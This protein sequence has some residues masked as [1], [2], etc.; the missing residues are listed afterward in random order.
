MPGLELPQGEITP[1]VRPAPHRPTL[2]ARLFLAVNHLPHTHRSDRYISDLSD[3]G[4][5]AGWIGACV[6]IAA[7]GGRR[8]RRAAL[9]AL[10]AAGV[11]TAVVEGGIK[12]IFRRGRPHFTRPAI[13]VGARPLDHS[14]PSG[15]S[16]TSFA[17]AGAL[18]GFYPLAAPLLLPAASMVGVSRMYLGH[19]YPSDVVV[20]ALLGAL[21]GRLGAAG[22]R[23]WVK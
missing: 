1:A 11:A 21:F 20:G 10:A 18:A 9:A 12:P 13:E 19:H 16:A 15:H 2:D 8:G 6:V 14:F 5:G 23:R 4:R 17:A 3:L 7:L 22:A